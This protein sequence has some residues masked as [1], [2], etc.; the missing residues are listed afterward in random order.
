MNISIII[1][2]KDKVRGS[3]MWEWSILW[4]T[5]FC[6]FVISVQNIIPGNLISYW[7]TSYP[8]TTSYK[9]FTV[10]FT[11]ISYSDNLNICQSITNN[12]LISRSSLEKLNIK[13]MTFF[14]GM[15]SLHLPKDLVHWDRNTIC[16]LETTFSTWF[17]KLYESFEAFNVSIY[18]TERRPSVNTT[19]VFTVGMAKLWV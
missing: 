2:L 3:W 4:G 6:N 10:N 15:L 8:A 1:A 17:F 5:R 12:I 7:G 19:S 18:K 9:G 11:T 14:L 13:V 16:S